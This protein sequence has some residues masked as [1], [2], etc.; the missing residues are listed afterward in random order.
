M[1]PLAV[2][3]A[4]HTLIE[5]AIVIAI[6]GIL[7]GYAAHSYREWIANSQIRTAAETLVEGLSAARN[8]A[9]RL[10][11]TVGFH[12]VS[13]LSTSCELTGKGSSWVVSIGNPAGECDQDASEDEAPQIVAKRAGSERTATVSIAALAADGSTEADSVRF[14]GVGRVVTGGTPIASIAVDSSVLGA[15]QTRDLRVI[16]SPGGMIRMC[17]PNVGEDDT[18]RCPEPEKAKP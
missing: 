13:N 18:R 6:A 9:I 5:M 8:E 7:L 15:D 1:R 2:H 16:V 17:D 3:Q 12:L 14:N 4:G 11:Q 10:N